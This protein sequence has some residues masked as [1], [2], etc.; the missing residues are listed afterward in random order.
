MGWYCCNNLDC[1]VYECG[2]FVTQGNTD[3][4]TQI[5]N[6]WVTEIA[7]HGAMNYKYTLVACNENGEKRD[8]TF[9]TRKILTEV[10]YLHPIK[11][12]RLI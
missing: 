10:F 9:E 2:F 11:K 3:Y 7:P 5:D 8:I 1:S 12:F 4:Y 6:R